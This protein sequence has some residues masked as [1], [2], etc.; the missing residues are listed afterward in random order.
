[1]D[2]PAPM[3]EVPAME[4]L[5]QRLVGETQSRP[6]PVMSPPEP[7]GLEQ[8][9]RSFLAGQQQRQRPP[10]RQ[11]PVRRDWNG[12]CVSPVGSPVMQQH[13]ARTWTNR[14]HL[15]SQD[16][17]RR[18][19]EG[20]YY[21]PTPG[22]DGP[23]AGGKRRLIREEGFVSRVSDHVRPRDPGGGGTVPTVLP[24][25]MTN[26]DVSDTPKLGEGDLSQSP[27]QTMVGD[28]PGRECPHE[29]LGMRLQIGKRRCQVVL[30]LMPTLGR[31]MGEGRCPFLV[32]AGRSLP[33]DVTVASELPVE[34]PQSVPL[35]VQWCGSIGP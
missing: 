34:G 24:R 20:I 35:Q 32:F 5:L 2:T 10:P 33:V 30:C 18:K 11:Q 23:S 15:C 3:P 9:L 29:D 19:L 31:R 17:G 22:G 6:P 14:F 7:A 13:G 21:D 4:K 27:P 8:M 12:V 26:D 25:R 16:G 28:T 1:M